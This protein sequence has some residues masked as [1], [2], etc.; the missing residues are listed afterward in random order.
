[1]SVPYNAD[2]G[3]FASIVSLPFKPNMII[4]DNR[5]AGWI[6]Q[7]VPRFRDE[8]TTEF[9]VIHLSFRRNRPLSVC[10]ISDIGHHQREEIRHGGQRALMNS[11]RRHIPAANDRQGPRGGCIGNDCR[12]VAEI[13]P[14][15]R[16]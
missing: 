5:L 1:M 8:D 2:I 9:G 14:S 12:A 3:D 6:S 4:A 15:A 13:E 10:Q 16:G 7:G 11:K